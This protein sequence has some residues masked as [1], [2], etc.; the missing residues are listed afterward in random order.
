MSFVK[1][2]RQGD[3]FGSCEDLSQA[4]NATNVEEVTAEVGLLGLSILP[5]TVI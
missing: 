4:L 5:R 1:L 2:L 3:Y